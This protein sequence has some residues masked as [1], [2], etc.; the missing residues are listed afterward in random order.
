MAFYAERWGT[1][2]GDVYFIQINDNGPIKIGRATNIKARLR[3]L[4]DAT[5]KQL[6]LIHVIKHGGNK[7]EKE[8]HHRFRKFNIKGEWFKP[9]KLILNYIKKSYTKPKPINIK[10]ELH[11][12][13]RIEKMAIEAIRKYETAIKN[14]IDSGMYGEDVI[15][16]WHINR[17]YYERLKNNTLPPID[18]HLKHLKEIQRLL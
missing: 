3:Y 2:E 9:S 4:Q 11:G 16:K 15:K 10:E 14:D 6:N 7:L 12:E 13:I 17:S 8:L 5:P 1:K 18:D